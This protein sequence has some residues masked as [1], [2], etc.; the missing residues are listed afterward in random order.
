MKAIE[1]N[2]DILVKHRNWL[3]TKPSDTIEGIHRKEQLLEEDQKEGSIYSKLKLLCDLWCALC[4]AVFH[5]R[6]H[7]VGAQGR[8]L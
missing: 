8:P 5:V 6:G 3:A 1:Q 7:G 2:V 4:S